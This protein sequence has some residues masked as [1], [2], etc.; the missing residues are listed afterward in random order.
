MAEQ[1][2]RGRAAGVLAGTSTVEAIAGVGAVVLAILGLADVLPGLMAPVATIAVGVALWIEG[3]AFAARQ[4]RYAR[5]QSGEAYAPSVG[6]SAE[7]LAGAAGTV[8]GVLALV[9][10]APFTLMAVA[11]T[12]YGTGLL[13]GAASWARAPEPAFHDEVPTTTTIGEATVVRAPVERRQG[14]SAELMRQTVGAAVGGQVLIGMAALVLGVCALVGIETATLVLS[15][16]LSLG[17]AVFL[18]ATA[19]GADLAALRRRR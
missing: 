18:T 9:R 3:G 13:L 2:M 17:V 8:L 1:V 12:L 5:E 19:A 16:M 15:G 6:T 7:L 4:A 14:F 10:V 11:L